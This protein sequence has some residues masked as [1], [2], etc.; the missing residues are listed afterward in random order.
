MKRRLIWILWPGFV[1]AIPAVGIVFTLFD[2][3]EMRLLG[4]PL[5]SSRLGAYT[6]GFL[7]FWA[8]CAASSALTCYLSRDER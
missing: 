7:F 6:V 4:A 5:E 3:A 2:P 1:M 8:L